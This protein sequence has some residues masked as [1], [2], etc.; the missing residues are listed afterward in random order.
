[1]ALVG[2]KSRGQFIPWVY[3]FFSLNLVLLALLL[4]LLTG[5]EK[6]TAKT[7]ID[8]A[9]DRWSDSL[10]G[11]FYD[12][13]ERL[14][15]GLSTIAM[16]IVPIAGGWIFRGLFLGVRQKEEAGRIEEADC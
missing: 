8:T 3:R 13:M 10:N 4:A 15:A 16:M 9:V 14:G 11:W 12:L 2:K 6:Y 5:Q 7:F 1:M